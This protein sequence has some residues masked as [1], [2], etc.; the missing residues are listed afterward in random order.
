MRGSV[1][2]L[3]V[4]G[5]G[6]PAHCERRQ[7]VF[8]WQRRIAMSAPQWMIYGAY[9][10]TGTLVVQEALRRGHR[11]LL[12]GRSSTKLA[13]LAD[14]LGLP[15]V[16]LD[17]QDAPAVRGALRDVNLVFHAAGPFAHTSAALVQACRASRTHYL[18]ISGEVAVHE[19]TLSQDKAARRAGIALI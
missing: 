18:D 6:S 17:L 19:H 1:S 3:L 2:T 4:R 15:W 12:A 8:P 7:P 10:H 14:S 16:A 13:P 11:P 9:G 5:R